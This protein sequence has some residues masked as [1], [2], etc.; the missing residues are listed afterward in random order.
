[1]VSLQWYK[2][3][4]DTQKIPFSEVL[5]PFIVNQKSWIINIVPNMKQ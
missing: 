4:E 5:N 1:M 3:M 2:K